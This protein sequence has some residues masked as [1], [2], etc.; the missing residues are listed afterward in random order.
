MG[1]ILNINKPQGETSYSVVASVKRLIG[2]RRV[3]H[4]GTLDPA[5]TGVLPVCFGQATRV[6]E[7]LGEATKVYRA[8]IELGVVT[9]TYDATG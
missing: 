9:D 2:E 6:I 3:G 1:G 8:Q 5:A 4:A 7:F